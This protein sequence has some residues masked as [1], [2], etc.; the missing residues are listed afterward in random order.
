MEMERDHHLP[1][2]DIISIRE[3]AELE[4]HPKNNEEGE[5]PDLEWVMETSLLPPYR[6]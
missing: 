6:Q 3:A 2:L 1:F 5:W 4:L